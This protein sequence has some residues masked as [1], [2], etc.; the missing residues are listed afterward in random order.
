MSVLAVGT[1]VTIKYTTFSGT[2]TGGII[3]NDGVYQ[4]KVSWTDEHG[5][6]QER[7]FLESQL[8][9]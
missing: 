8:D 3:D 2:V 5:A 1:A 4:V 7:Y 9:V 6:L